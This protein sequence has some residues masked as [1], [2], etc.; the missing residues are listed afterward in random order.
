MTEENI[1]VENYPFINAMNLKKDEA[2]YFKFEEDFVEEN[3]RCIPMCV[4]FK[5]DA[6]GI[7][8]Q[9]SEW[10]KMSVAERNN[11]AEMSCITDK[12]IRKYKSYLKHIL[13]NYTSK[14]A[15]ELSVDQNLVWSNVYKIPQL[16]I[17][18]LEEFEWVI[19]LR[20][21]KELSNLQRFVL[22]KLCKPGHE[23]KNFPMAVKEFGLI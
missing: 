11:L 4:R 14:K 7:K 21:W 2:V 17:E 15:T 23:N 22:M 20:Q 18:K 9:L 12:D 3:I 5:L 16:L 1:I 6:C 13:F 19:S 8:L 10:S